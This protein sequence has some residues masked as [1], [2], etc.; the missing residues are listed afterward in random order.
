M[1]DADFNIKRILQIILPAIFLFY[2]FYVEN[3]EFPVLI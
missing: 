3:M 2:I 1:I